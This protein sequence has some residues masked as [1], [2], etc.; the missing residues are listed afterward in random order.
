MCDIVSYLLGKKAGGTGTNNATIDI[1]G[2][3]GSIQE[4]ITSISSL[5]TSNMTSMNQLFY[6]CTRLVSLPSYLNTSNVTDMDGAFQS[7]NEL[8]TLPN[9]DTSNVT[10]MRNMCYHCIKLKNIPILN[11]SKVTNFSGMFSYSRGMLSDESL[12]NLLIM[13]ANA[14][15]YTGTKTLSTLGFTSSMYTSSKIQSLPNY[16]DFIDAGWTIGY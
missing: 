9:M 14:T 13:C 6:N 2:K 8:E 3:N 16:Q 11:T 15:S 12:N 1:T 7:C 4:F 5:D 10:S